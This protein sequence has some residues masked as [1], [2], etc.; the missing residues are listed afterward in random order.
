LIKSGLFEDSLVLN[1]EVVTIT[2]S[3]CSFSNSLLYSNKIND[4]ILECFS[5]Q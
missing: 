4:Y 2:L 3:F 5:L 1:V